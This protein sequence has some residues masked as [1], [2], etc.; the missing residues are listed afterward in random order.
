M[1]S[2]ILKRVLIIIAC[3]CFVAVFYVLSLYRAIDGTEDLQGAVKAFDRI[4]LLQTPSPEMKTIVAD[5]CLRIA[6]GFRDSLSAMQAKNENNAEQAE[7]IKNLAVNF[8][9]KAIKLNPRTQYIEDYLTF[10][11]RIGNKKKSAE[12]YA[13]LEQLY[14]NDRKS[15]MFYSMIDALTDGGYLDEAITKC[16][17]KLVSLPLE[18]EASKQRVEYG[19]FVDNMRSKVHFR[20]GICYEKKADTSLALQ[21]YFKAIDSEKLWYELYGQGD[22]HYLASDCLERISIIYYHQGKYE[23]AV[24]FITKSTPVPKDE[25]GKIFFYG[26]ELERKYLLLGD[27]YLKLGKKAEAMKMY[28]KVLSVWYKR[29]A[30]SKEGKLAI[31]KLLSLRKPV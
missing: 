7:S 25:F 2:K 4:S 19:K 28:E 23:Q 22:G 26:A 17:N 15:A 9:E 11:E 5:H 6:Y 16:Q 1:K 14:P 21:S 31:E 24:E 20:L 12:L 29:G 27:I 30:E 8:F 13:T 3:I 10:C 18:S